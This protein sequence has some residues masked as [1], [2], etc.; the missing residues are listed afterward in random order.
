MYIYIYVYYIYKYIYICIYIYI[1][2]HVYLCIYIYTYV[3]IGFPHNGVHW[4]PVQIHCSKR[5]LVPL[6]VID[7][8]M[9]LRGTP[10]MANFTASLLAQF[11]NPGFQLEWSVSMIVSLG[12]QPDVLLHDYI[13]TSQS[14]SFWTIYDGFTEQLCFLFENG[15]IHVAAQSCRKLTARAD[16]SIIP[17]EEHWHGGSSVGKKPSAFWWILDE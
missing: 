16:V 2:I 3:D 17:P 5:S 7:R 14:W 15:G 4:K 9:G 1:Y 6:G 10:R 12:Q 13:V 8:N 11:V